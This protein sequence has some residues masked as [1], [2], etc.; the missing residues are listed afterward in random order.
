[1]N[2]RPFSFGAFF[3]NAI[4]SREDKKPSKK[5]SSSLVIEFLF[6]PYI[7]LFGT[8]FQTYA[9]KHRKFIFSV[10][11]LMFQGGTSN[12]QALCN[13]WLQNRNYQIAKSYRAVRCVLPVN[14]QLNCKDFVANIYIYIYIY[15]YKVV[16][17]T[18]VICTCLQVVP[19]SDKKQKGVRSSFRRSLRFPLRKEKQL[20]REYR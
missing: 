17:K 4:V 6:M 19:L 18:V 1:M 16:C 7:Q 5:E 3:I 20:N 14:W 8:S 10:F 15:I 9:F 13:E 11:M 2:G 12:H